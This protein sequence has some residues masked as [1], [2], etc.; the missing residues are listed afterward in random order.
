MFNGIIACLFLFDRP[1]ELW[2]K[3][4]IETTGKSQNNHLPRFSRPW[5]NVA[6]DYIKVYQAVS[7]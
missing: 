2:A 7:I 1:T 3:Y 4:V 5:Q 6:E